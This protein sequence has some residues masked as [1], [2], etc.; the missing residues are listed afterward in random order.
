[1]KQHLALAALL[2]GLALSAAGAATG[3]ASPDA[4]A[5]NPFAQA[6]PTK[7][8]YDREYPVMHYGRTPTH[9]AIARLQQRLAAGEIK[10]SLRSAT[11]LSGFAARG[12][13]HRCEFP[14]PGV[15][16][17]QFSDRLHQCRNAAGPVFR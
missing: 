11:R 16:E 14:G 9:N 13:A 15:L 4:A 5:P 8:P 7:L 3:Q 12:T 2:F 6:P 17:D 1:M 10:L